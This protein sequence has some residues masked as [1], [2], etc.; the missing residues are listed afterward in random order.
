MS[1]NTLALIV[2]GFV[3]GAYLALFLSLRAI[4]TRRSPWLALG[5]AALCSL[6]WPIALPRSGIDRFVGFWL[7]GLLFIGI[8]YVIRV[9]RRRRTE[10]T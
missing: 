3:V 9:V 6:V 10:G 1:T 4:V 5:A 8:A 2:T 7:A